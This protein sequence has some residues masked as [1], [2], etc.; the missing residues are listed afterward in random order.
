MCG[1]VVPESVGF[2]GEEFF[3][4]VLLSGRNLSENFFRRKQKSS[5]GDLIFREFQ[6]G[7]EI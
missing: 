1:T 5:F 4:L 7:K 6:Q 3:F 2:V